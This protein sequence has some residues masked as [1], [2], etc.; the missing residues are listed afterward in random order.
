MKLFVLVSTGQ[1][2][3]NLP[4][5]LELAQPGDRVLWIESPEAV[6][7]NWTAGPRAVLEEQGLVTAGLVRV[8]HLN[9][10]CQLDQALKPFVEQSR[11]GY[12]D[13]YLVTNGGKKHT[14]IGLLKAFDAMF[15]KLLYAEERPVVC[16]IYPPGL[17]SSPLILPYNRHRLDLPDI[18][19]LN[20]YTLHGAGICKRLWPDGLPAEI[21][22]ELYGRDE[23]Y[24]YLLH[25]RHTGSKSERKYVCRGKY[26]PFEKLP[27]VAPDRYN[28]W[29][30]KLSEVGCPANEQSL[31]KIYYSTIKLVR[32][33]PR[34]PHYRGGEKGDHDLLLGPAFERAVARRVHQWQA[35]HPHPAIQSIWTGVK[36]AHQ[37]TPETVEAEFD[38]LLVMRN[39]LL[40]HLECKSGN[41]QPGALREL[42]V[43]I[44]RLRL[45]TSRRSRLAVVVPLFTRCHAEPWFEGMHRTWV[46]LKAGLGCQHVLPFTWPGQPAS[47]PAPEDPS[48]QT[49]SCPSFEDALTSLL[50]P[51]HP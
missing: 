29:L 14:S 44:H 37:S 27:D 5:V 32:L 36:I 41:V 20:G 43:G 40:I 6:R 16:T 21:A 47:Y 4:P 1:K 39:G 26:L 15:P 3:A 34:R 19:R 10:P 45:G 23:D 18:L 30:Q 22:H 35:A 12:H 2:V 46:R 50:L 9:D 25:A 8:G 38:V 13:V 17:D 28:R 42:D 24:T 31:R 7:E 51:Y 49:I 11:A 48:G 33:S